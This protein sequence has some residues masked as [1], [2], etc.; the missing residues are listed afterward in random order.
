MEE[1]DD[2]NEHTMFIDCHCH[3][4]DAVFDEDRELVIQHA[5]DHADVAHILAVSSG[6]NDM[7]KVLDV[8]RDPRFQNIVLPCLG[9]HPEQYQTRSVTGLQE[10][11][12]VLEAI[13][14]HADEIVGMLGLS[15]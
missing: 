14:R 15:V 5:K 13:R 3:I 9:V 4:S 12:P 10:A 6:A 1:D 2:E 11:V 8:S 7:Q